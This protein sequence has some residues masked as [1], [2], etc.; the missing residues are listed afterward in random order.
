MELLYDR[1]V[2]RCTMILVAVVVMASS[3]SGG[4][5]LTS[6]MPAALT[7]PTPQLMLD[8]FLELRKVYFPSCTLII[9]HD[10]P[11]G[12]SEVME[13]VSLILQDVQLASHLIF[14]LNESF[15]DVLGQVDLNTITLCPAYISVLWNM[16][17]LL[18]VVGKPLWDWDKYLTSRIHV[19]FNLGPARLTAEALKASTKTNMHN[20]G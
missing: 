8:F 3:Y 13:L 19:I 5:P 11:D 16:D 10:P 4:N 1:S 9:L 15:P 6:M 14:T 18:R 2:C 12:H 17:G 7:Q 20:E